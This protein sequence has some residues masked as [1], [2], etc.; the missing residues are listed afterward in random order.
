MRKQQNVYNL[1]VSLYLQQQVTF[2][3]Y[4]PKRN[5]NFSHGSEHTAT[6]VNGNCDE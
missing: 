4:G 5:D 3:N 2:S 1:N 6:V